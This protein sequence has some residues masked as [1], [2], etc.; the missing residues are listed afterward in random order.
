MSS[1]GDERSGRVPSRSLAELV[2]PRRPGDVAYEQGEDHDARALLIENG[3][4]TATEELIGLL[5]AEIGILQAAA[6]RTLG[7]RYERSAASPLERVAQ[8]AGVEET[9]R[10]QAAF[11]LARMGVSDGGELLI[12]L[13]GLS[14]EATPAP[15]H[16]AGALAQLGDPRGFEVVRIALDSPN[17]VTAM[18]ACK[19]LYAFAAL[20]GRPLPGSG[21]VDA[22]EAFGRALRRPESNIS[23]EARAQLKAL[24]TEK[25]RETLRAH[26]DGDRRK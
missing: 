20:D 5:D 10:V 9:V 15:L 23:G 7:A 6:A 2:V 8:D 18:V 4:T 1:E 17:P 3:Y 19:Q 22:F 14:P 26:S 12:K 24:G 25:A 13:L 16:A 11:A 21:R